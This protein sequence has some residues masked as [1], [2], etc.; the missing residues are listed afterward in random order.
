MQSLCETGYVEVEC[1]AAA[2]LAYRA[3][4]WVSQMPLKSTNTHRLCCK[5]PSLQQCRFVP[6]H[7]PVCLCPLPVVVTTSS[8]RTQLLLLLLLC[9]VPPLCRSMQRLA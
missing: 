1:W 3:S 2:H 8:W 5:L 9:F 7:V 6:S 4:H